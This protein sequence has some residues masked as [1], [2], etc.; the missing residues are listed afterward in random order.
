[1]RLVFALIAF[2]LAGTAH[3]QPNPC[4]GALPRPGTTFGGIVR[5]VLDGD[6]M[7][8]SEKPYFKTWIKIRL[9]DFDAPELKRPG[10]DAAKAALEDIAMGQRVVCVSGGRSFD[11]AVA[12]CAIEGKAVGAFMRDEGIEEGGQR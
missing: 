2:G 8:V 9:A 7:C 4:P 3:A 10:G 11:R 6:T 5:M 12:R 1:M